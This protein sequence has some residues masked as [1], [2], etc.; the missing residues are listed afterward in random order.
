M[1]LIDINVKIFYGSQ[2][3]LDLINR[4]QWQKSSIEKTKSVIYHFA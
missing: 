4:S 2:N 1:M 3:V